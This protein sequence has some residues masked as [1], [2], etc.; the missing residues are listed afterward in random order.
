M[1]RNNFLS[2]DNNRFEDNNSRDVYTYKSITFQY[3]SEFSDWVDTKEYTKDH[4]QRQKKYYSRDFEGKTFS[5]PLELHKYILSKGKDINNIIKSVRG[6][7]NFCEQC[8]KLPI[9][10]ITKY[11]TLLKLRKTSTDFRVPSDEEVI[12]GYGSVKNNEIL[13]LVFLVLATSGI[14]YVE[15]L[16]F[17]KT[18]DMSRFNVYSNYVCYNVSSLRHTKNINNIYLPMFVYERLTKIEPNPQALKMTLKRKG[19]VFSWKYLRKWQY[20]FLIYNNVPE[21]VAD[22][23]QGRANRSV[24]SNHYLARG[25]QAGY[26]YEKIV[27]RLN[28][29]LKQ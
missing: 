27:E 21:S 22:F 28:E 18:Y 17:L 11:R 20:N 1:A 10:L 19:C 5:S 15:C 23:I 9:E 8:D 24:S 3:A 2:L 6:Y 7:L 12:N 25:Q 29:L 4:S 13:E 26:W 16:E 14:R